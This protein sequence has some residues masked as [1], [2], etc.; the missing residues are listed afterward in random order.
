MA[1]RD[2][3]MVVRHG[4]REED[5]RRVVADTSDVPELESHLADWLESGGW[6]RSRWREF[7]AEFVSEGRP[8]TVRGVA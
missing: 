7:T 6:S 4:G 2:C 5:R 3:T 1:V 8:V